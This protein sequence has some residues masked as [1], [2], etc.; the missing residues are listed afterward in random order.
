MST[1]PKEWPQKWR[2]LFLLTLPISGPLWVIG[3]F[4]GVILIVLFAMG[5]IVATF[6]VE[7]WTGVEPKWVKARD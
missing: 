6:A 4:V 5:L 7:L 3:M 1:N 2:R